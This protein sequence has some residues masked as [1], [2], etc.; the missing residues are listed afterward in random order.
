VGEKQ[1]G[2]RNG[3][4][5]AFYEARMCKDV[6]SEREGGKKPGREKRMCKTLQTRLHKNKTNRKLQEGRKMGA[7]GT[8]CAFLFRSLTKKKKKRNDSLTISTVKGE[9]K[10]KKRGEK[11]EP[12]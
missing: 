7:V 9:E 10:M 3:G 1:E 2:E 12:N 6:A 11:R 8:Y 5:P 4:L